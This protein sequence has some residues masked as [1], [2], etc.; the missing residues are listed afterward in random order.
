MANFWP[1][2]AISKVQKRCK[3]HQNLKRKWLFCLKF[4][5][6]LVKNSTFQLKNWGFFR[7][8][9]SYFHESKRFFSWIWKALFPWLTARTKNWKIVE[10]WAISDNFG[11]SCKISGKNGKISEKLEMVI[12]EFRKI[13]G[14]IGTFWKKLE[15]FGKNGKIWGKI[16]EKLQMVMREF[17]KIWGKIGKFWYKL[18][19]FWKRRK[20]WGKI[21]KFWNKTGRF[22]KNPKI[23]WEMRKNLKWNQKILRRNRKK[24]LA[25]KRKKK[26]QKNGGKISKN[27]NPGKNAEKKIQGK[28][29]KKI[30]RFFSLD[31]S[32]AIFCLFLTTF[33]YYYHYHYVL[34]I[35]K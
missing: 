30:S 25:R 13:W 7:Y 4:W 28:K 11:K 15:N 10:L 26:V 34:H 5:R 31:F 6:K 27:N 32:F 14:K 9:S 12:G 18:E 21:G 29:S 16:S 20:I 24:F 33:G 8:I 22:G 3:M 23:S 1:L 2:L 35:H 19:N 17:G